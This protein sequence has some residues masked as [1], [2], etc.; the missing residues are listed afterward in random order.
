M[1]KGAALFDA[2]AISGTKAMVRAGL[3]GC[4]LVVAGVGGRGAGPIAIGVAAPACAQYNGG[5]VVSMTDGAVTF[6]GGN[7]SNAMAVMRARMFRLLHVC[8]I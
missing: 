6:K 7:I 3:A 1:T 2:V 5:G 8:R 4:A